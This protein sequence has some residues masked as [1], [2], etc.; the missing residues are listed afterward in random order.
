[1]LYTCK[2][3]NQF[4]TPAFRTAK[5]NILSRIMISRDKDYGSTQFIEY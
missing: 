1:M 2:I 4:E 3:P 5:H